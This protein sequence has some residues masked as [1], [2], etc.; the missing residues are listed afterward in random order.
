MLF[1]IWCWSIKCNKAEQITD[2]K[3]LVSKI[4]KEGIDYDC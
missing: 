3:I 2:N 1:T 4:R